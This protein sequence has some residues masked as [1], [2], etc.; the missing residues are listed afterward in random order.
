MDSLEK[1]TIKSVIQ[2]STIMKG[3]TRGIF[4]SLLTRISLII[5]VVLIASMSILYI[6]DQFFG[7]STDIFTLDVIVPSLGISLL[8]VFTQRNLSLKYIS[9]ITLGVTLIYTFSHVYLFSS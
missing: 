7:R 5:I 1:G 6:I 9:M 8:I 4:F 3:S 2:I